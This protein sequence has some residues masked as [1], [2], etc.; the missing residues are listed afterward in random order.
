M[1]RL[2]Q[3]PY[4][5]QYEYFLDLLQQICP[6]Y[7]TVRLHPD[8]G[9]M[10]QWQLSNDGGTGAGSLMAVVSSEGDV[11]YGVDIGW[12]DRDVQFIDLGGSRSVTDVASELNRYMK[13]AIECPDESMEYIPVWDR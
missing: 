6:P 1:L 10:A 2:D 12:D 13:Y 11:M 5:K 7:P 4:N 8:G 9:A 3:P